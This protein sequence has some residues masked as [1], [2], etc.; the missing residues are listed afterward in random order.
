V[1]RN[2]DHEICGW[3]GKIPPRFYLARSRADKPVNTYISVID[4]E[5]IS[6]YPMTPRPRT[7]DM[8]IGF[9]APALL[10]QRMDGGGWERE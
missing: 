6:G 4:I 2:F 1:L 7:P 10:A 5:R 8:A 3:Y 9:F